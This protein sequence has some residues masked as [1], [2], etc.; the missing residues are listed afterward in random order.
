MPTIVYGGNWYENGSFHSRN[1]SFWQ[2]DTISGSPVYYVTGHSPAWS[3]WKSDA[4]YHWKE[5]TGKSEKEYT[6]GGDDQEWHYAGFEYCDLVTSKAAHSDSNGDGKCDT[7]SYVMTIN[8]STLSITAPSAQTYTGSAINA[9]P[10]VKNGSTTLTEGTHYTLSWS[11]NTN[12]GT[13]TVTVTGIGTY[14]GS[15]SVNFSITNR[16][17]TITAKDQAVDGNV[18]ISTGTG[19]VTVGGSRTWL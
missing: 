14:T 15:K 5:C 13:A 17:I 6:Y 16:A 19:Q 18:G 1:P 3:G 8:V 2:D 4:S 7:C 12:P 10:T 9:K 11:N